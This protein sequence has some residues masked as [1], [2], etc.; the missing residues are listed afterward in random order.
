[1]SILELASNSKQS[2]DCEKVSPTALTYHTKDSSEQ[3]HDRITRKASSSSSSGS[4]S[5]SSHTFKGQNKSITFSN[6]KDSENSHSGN[7]ETMLVVV[8][9]LWRDAS[10]DE[11]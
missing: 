3:G 2:G 1:M 7:E 9:S 4:S 8:R 6:L 5:K 10:Q 11:R